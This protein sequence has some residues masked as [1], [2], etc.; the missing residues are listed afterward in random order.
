MYSF[1]LYITLNDL[2]N[3]DGHSLCSVRFRKS[4]SLHGASD[5]TNTGDKF[6]T[7]DRSIVC[8]KIRIFYEIYID[9]VADDIKK[10]ICQS[11]NQQ[12][13]KQFVPEPI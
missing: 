8:R 11:G 10:K 5:K 7:L 4:R 9:Q 2:E 6:A 3:K 12:A 1:I 13:I